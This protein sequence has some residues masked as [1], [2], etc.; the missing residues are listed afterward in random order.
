MADS[1]SIEDLKIGTREHQEFFN[2]KEQERLDSFAQ[3]IRDKYGPESEETLMAATRNVLL[4]RMANNILSFMEVVVDKYG[5]EALDIIGEG[6]RRMWY[7]RSKEIIEKLGIKEKDASAA[8]KV[9]TFAH[10]DLGE[11]V[12]DTPKKAAR[13]ERYCTHWQ[14]WGTRGC[15]LISNSSCR[16]MCDAV[17]PDLVVKHEKL[18]SEGDEYCRIVFELE[19]PG[20]VPPKG[21]RDWFS[22]VVR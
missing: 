18:I 13:H 14:K 12:E 6:N 4:G 19:E 2:M 20:E 1:S 9:L 3:A 11:V 16:G 21:E 15:C 17:N 5:T 22:R 10:R 7:E 8:M